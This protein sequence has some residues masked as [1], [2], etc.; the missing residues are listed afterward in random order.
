MSGA[1]RRMETADT[2]ANSMRKKL[3]RV[4]GDLVVA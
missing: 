2:R 1:A 3:T 4:I